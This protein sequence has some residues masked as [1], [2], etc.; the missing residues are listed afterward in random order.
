MISLTSC[1]IDV[2]TEVK[3]ANHFLLENRIHRHDA[4]DTSSSTVFVVTE[5]VGGLLNH[6]LVSALLYLQVA[7]LGISRGIFPVR[8]WIINI[9]II[10]GYATLMQVL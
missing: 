8:P 6:A 9:S 1:S 4:A 7:S 3:M 2:T 5:I 10:C